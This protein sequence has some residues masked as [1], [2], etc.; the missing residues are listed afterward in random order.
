[1][2]EGVFFPPIEGRGKGKEKRQKKKDPGNG[3][4]EGTSRKGR[5][6]KSGGRKNGLPGTFPQKRNCVWKKNKVALGERLPH[7]GLQLKEKKF[8][9]KLTKIDTTKPPPVEAGAGRE[10]KGPPVYKINLITEKSKT[11]HTTRVSFQRSPPWC[12]NP[13]KR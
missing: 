1:V 8:P 13:T 3:T 7:R 4:P 12:P 10:K 9:R 11:I 6:T 2:N 5:R